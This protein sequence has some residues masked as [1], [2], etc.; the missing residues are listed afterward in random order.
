MESSN[1]AVDGVTDK[2]PE[3]TIQSADN[4]DETKV[5]KPEK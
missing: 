3:D 5:N 4:A 2:H 1:L